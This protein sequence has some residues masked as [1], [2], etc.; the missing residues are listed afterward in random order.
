MGKLKKF[1]FLIYEY[2]ISV[3]L[4]INQK[5]KTKVEK[6]LWYSI[7]FPYFLVRTL[8]CVICEKTVAG[9]KIKVEKTK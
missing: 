4:K 9:R 7:Y 3:C 1:L 5:Y 6:M 2:N 8:Y